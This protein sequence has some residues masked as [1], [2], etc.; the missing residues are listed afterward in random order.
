MAVAP[1]G[2]VIWSQQAWRIRMFAGWCHLTLPPGGE[3][4]LNRFSIYYDLV[5]AFHLRFTMG[6]ARPSSG[7][8]EAPPLPRLTSRYTTPPKNGNKSLQKR[9]EL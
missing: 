9:S 4:L 2:C 1:V 6:V 8:K 7:R 3:C 5:P